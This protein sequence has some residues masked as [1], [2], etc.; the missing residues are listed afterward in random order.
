M[1]EELTAREKEVMQFIER[2]KTVNQYSPT[3]REIAAGIHT[4]STPHVRTMLE[5]LEELGYITKTKSPRT[6][7]VKKFVS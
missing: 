7:V 4:S 3:V 2:F 1:K 5:H 6:I